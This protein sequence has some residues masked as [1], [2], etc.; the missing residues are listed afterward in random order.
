[1]ERKKNRRDETKKQ[2]V[3]AQHFIF[4]AR[5][6]DPGEAADGFGS[7]VT[8]GIFSAS[9]INWVR[10][11]GETRR[12]WLLR[13]LYKL[14]IPRRAVMYRATARIPRITARLTNISHRKSF[15]K[16][17]FLSKLV[18]CRAFPQVWLAIG[19]LFYF[20]ERINDEIFIIEIHDFLVFIINDRLSYC[21]LYLH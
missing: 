1:M 6:K 13:L 17:A 12:A 18:F 11:P 7:L 14:F 9:M 10:R 21:L 5:N 16:R 4:N 19:G 2:L 3:S 20:S 8:I 15:N